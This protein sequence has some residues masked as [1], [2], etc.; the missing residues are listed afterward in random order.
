M[1]SGAV[2]LGTIDEGNGFHGP[3]AS[4][5]S[6]I[7]VTNRSHLI[8]VA[9]DD[10]FDCSSEKRQVTALSRRASHEIEAEIV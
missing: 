10:R 1:I 2:L 8:S 5:G 3:S 6:N 4:F 9:L 7:A